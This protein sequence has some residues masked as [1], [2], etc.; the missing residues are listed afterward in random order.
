L[1][2]V[3]FFLFFNFVI[4]T[5]TYMCIHYLPPHFTPPPRFQADLFHALV[6]QFCWRE[7]IRDSKTRIAFLL[8]WHK[9]SCTERFLVL[10]P[11]ICVLQSTHESW[12]S[13][14]TVPLNSMQSA[15]FLLLSFIYLR[16]WIILFYGIIKSELYWLHF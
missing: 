13:A 5:F 1:F 8:V 6:L 14:L 2:N 16:N 7:N 3:E 11:G 15:G 4:F 9:D 10:L 12:N